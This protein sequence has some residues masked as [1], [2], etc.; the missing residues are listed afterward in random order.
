[1]N[2]RFCQ[3]RHQ[4]VVVLG[5]TAS[6]GASRVARMRK[7]VSVFMVGGNYRGNGNGFAEACVMEQKRA[8]SANQKLALSSEKKP[9]FHAR[10]ECGSPAFIPVNTPTVAKIDMG[11]A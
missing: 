5:H 8:R 3:E 10:R 2:K 1:M 11:T 7:A 6:A 9:S 4:V